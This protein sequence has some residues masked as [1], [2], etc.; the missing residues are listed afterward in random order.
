MMDTPA[1]GSAVERYLATLEQQRRAVAA[2][3]TATAAGTELLARAF[4]TPRMA[5]AGLLQEGVTVLAGRPKLGKSWMA[6]GLSL[7]VAAGEPALGAL[8]VEHGGALYL[9]LE[10]GERRLQGR[11]QAALAGRAMPAGWEYAVQW[12]ALDAG[13]LDALEGWLAARPDARLVVID[14]LKRVR[15]RETAGS[16][17][18]QDYD[19]IAPL[20]DLARQ[21]RLSVLVVHHTRKSAAEDALD[22]ISGS[23][24]LTA[25][26]DAA[27]VLQRARGEAE[28][29]LTVTGR[30]LE[31]RELA[32]RRDAATPTWTL[33]G[34]AAEA[35]Q[36]KERRAVLEALAAAGRPLGPIELAAALG[37]ADSAAV[38]RLLFKLVAG[39]QVVQL[40]RG[41][42]ALPADP[43]ATQ[44]ARAEAAADGDD[45]FRC[46]VCGAPAGAR[47]ASGQP[48][49]LAHRAE[50][51][52]M[53][54]QPPT[55]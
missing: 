46:G 52:R 54:A 41:A 43:P 7:A 10:D 40:K 47:R 42:Y 51:D 3:P 32:L 29:T 24:G 11:L 45:D 19:A 20:A 39:G 17:Y 12:P 5:V 38:R 2:P 26:A 22:L 48:L 16:L 14:T 18:G 15:P 55:G 37:Q 53:A 4:P 6:L 28:A 13:G 8:A 31:E 9:A 34:S 49:C 27:L 44:A 36:S 23:T 35:R 30:D 1:V 25:A 21:R 50:A 33:L